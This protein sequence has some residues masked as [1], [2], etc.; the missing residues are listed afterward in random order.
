[1]FE[2]VDIYSSITSYSFNVLSIESRLITCPFGLENFM[3][4]YYTLL[5]CSVGVAKRTVLSLGVFAGP[6]EW[7]SAG[8]STAWM[9]LHSY[10]GM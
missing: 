7:R 8:L 10:V 5:I 4:A 3:L 6:S 1:M 9:E 2:I